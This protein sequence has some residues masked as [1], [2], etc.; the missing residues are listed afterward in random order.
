MNRKTGLIGF[1]AKSCHYA[2]EHIDDSETW[3]DIDRE[4]RLECTSFQV[5]CFLAQNT[6]RGS[7]GVEW[8]VVIDDLVAR[9]MK[10]EKQWR[11]V[12]EALVADL[13][14]IKEV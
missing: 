11:G 14:G 7:D 9:P 4:L 8:G 1:L 12:L 6:R 2:Q 10:S 3:G 13:G 5:A